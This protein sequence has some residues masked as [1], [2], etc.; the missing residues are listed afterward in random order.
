MRHHSNAILLALV[1]VSTSGCALVKK[2]A[3]K[4]K[5]E[6]ASAVPVAAFLTAADVTPGALETTDKEALAEFMYESSDLYARRPAHGAASTNDKCFEAEM[7]KTT[8]VTTKTTLTYTATIDLTACMKADPSF[9]GLTTAGTVRVL[10][11][12]GCEG[13]DLSGYN[14]KTMKELIGENGNLAELCDKGPTRSSLSNQSSSYTFKGTSTAGGKSTK[15]D[16]ETKTAAAL[17]MD[18]MTACTETLVGDTWTTNAGCWSAS[19]ATTV[20]ALVNDAVIEAQGKDDYEKFAFDALKSKNDKT[21]VYFSGGKIAVTK[22]KWT[23][24]VTYTAADKAPAWTMTD[25]TSTAKGVIGTNSPPA[26]VELTA[27]GAP[28]LRLNGPNL[29]HVIVR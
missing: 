27:D 9:A 2:E 12:L 19:K 18:G 26:L 4:D 16:Y 24:T 15:Y 13:G 8:V 22:N 14:G 25:G 7:N 3:N 21:S 11:S 1:L 28:A 23:G 6:S 5:G 17:A 29:R 20:R 10:A